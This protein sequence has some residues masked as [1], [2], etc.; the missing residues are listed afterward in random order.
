MQQP[1]TAQPELQRQQAQQQG[2]DDSAATTSASSAE[3][4][5]KRNAYL[6]EKYGSAEA[7]VSLSSAEVERMMD[8][9]LRESPTVKYLLAALKQVRC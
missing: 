6:E 9:V 5:S 8:A 7:H 2:H 4:A 1:L 3:P